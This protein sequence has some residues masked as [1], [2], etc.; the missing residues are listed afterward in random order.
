MGISNRD[1]IRDSDNRPGYASHLGENWAIKYLLI[2][3]VVVF[4]MQQ[5]FSNNPEQISN[6]LSL[7]TSDLKSFQLWRLVTYGFCH[8]SFQHIFFNMF[9][10][11][12]FGRMVESIYGSREFLAFYLVGVVI[13]GLC[14][15]LLQVAEGGQAAVI[16]ASGGVNAV[17]FLCAMHYPRMTVLLMFVIPVQF[18]ILAIGYALIDLFMMIRPGESMVAHAAHLG[19][20]AFG[21]AYKHYG[22][23]V[24][25]WLQFANWRLPKRQKRPKPNPNIRAYQ[26][27]EDSLD[28]RVDELLAKINKHGEAS[29][30]DEERRILTEASKRYKDRR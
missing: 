10:L 1:Y 12:M 3:N 26:P 5:M 8:G 23:R 28:N 4:L 16:G 20:A 27:P 19:G 17:V 14:H 13:S 9:V 2:A 11:W 30:T 15:V 18:W 21:V 24:L 29:L 7:S 6:L 25:S 22:W